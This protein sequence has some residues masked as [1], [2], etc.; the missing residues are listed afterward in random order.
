LQVHYYRAAA[1]ADHLRALLAGGTVDVIHAT[2]IRML[3]YVWNIHHPPVVVDLIDSL[4]LNLAD[5]RTQVRGP[6][7]LGYELEY[8]RVQAYEQAVVR[9]FPALVLSSPADKEALGGG[10]QITVIPNGVDIERFPFHGPAGRD[11][12]TLVFTGNMG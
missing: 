8:G 4:S 3:P 5:R 7:R 6:K 11:P 1:V 2:L 10:D 12:A 9:H